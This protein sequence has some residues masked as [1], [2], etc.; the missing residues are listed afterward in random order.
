MIQITT[1]RVRARRDLAHPR[2]ALSARSSSPPSTCTRR[3]RE[4]PWIGP[5]SVKCSSATPSS[6]WASPST[7][8]SCCGSSSA[9]SRGMANHHHRRYCLPTHPSGSAPTGDDVNSGTRPEPA[10][11][12]QPASA[13]ATPTPCSRAATSPSSASADARSTRC[14]APLRRRRSSETR[15][16]MIR[17]HDYRE[18]LE[19]CTYDK[20]RVR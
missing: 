1:S 15:K 12:Q 13:S 5:S 9:S 7:S 18:L 11:H 16:P 2:T 19:R 14:S 6:G 4:A 20:E 10:P 8:T 17:A 3:E